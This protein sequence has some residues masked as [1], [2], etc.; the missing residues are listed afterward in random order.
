MSYIK[1]NFTLIHRSKIILIF[2]IIVAFG[3]TG[4]WLKCRLGINFSDHYSLSRHLPFKYIAPDAIIAHPSPGILFEDSFNSFTF[5]GGWAR[6]WPR[7]RRL[8]E[9]SYDSGGINNSRCLIIQN[10]SKETWSLSHNKRIRVH[11]GEKFS[12]EVAVKLEGKSPVAHAEIAAY[13]KKHKIIS[14][15]YITKTTSQTNEWIT[16]KKTF[17][18]PADISYIKFRL[19]GEGEGR[20]LFDDVRFTMDPKVEISLIHKGSSSLQ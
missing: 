1:N 16:L 10:K 6:L 15:H 20:F 17:I 13:K 19:S 7:E 12:F 8:V 18:V 4:Y 2:L 9:K 14:L 11:N 3:L 5:F